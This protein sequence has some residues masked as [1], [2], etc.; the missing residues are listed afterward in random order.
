MKKLFKT[1]KSLFKIKKNSYCIDSVN[2]ENMIYNVIINQVRLANI[3]YKGYMFSI[4][5]T[6]NYFIIKCQTYHDVFSDCVL[7]LIFCSM[8]NRERLINY[9]NKELK[10][11]INEVNYNLN[12]YKVSKNE[13]DN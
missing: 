10:V 9:I 1:I 3:H 11:L 5:P 12:C 8:Y 7:S 4:V 6:K 13:K 2:R